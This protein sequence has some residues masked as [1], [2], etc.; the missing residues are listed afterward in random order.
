MRFHANKISRIFNFSTSSSRRAISLI[1]PLL[2]GVLVLGW[3]AC[4]PSGSPV[5]YVATYGNDQW[6]GKLAAPNQAH[7]DGP[8]A[9]LLRA[10]DE[11]RKSRRRPVAVVV[12]PGSYYLAETLAL[13]PQDSG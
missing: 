13:E 7:S 11:A 6:S 12:E 10:R 1:L 3:T 5:Y 8:F 2:V 4:S 9:T